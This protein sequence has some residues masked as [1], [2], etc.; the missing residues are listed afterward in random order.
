MRIKLQTTLKTTTITNEITRNVVM[1]LKNTVNGSD[2][3]M[4]SAT[5]WVS[6]G[7]DVLK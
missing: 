2:V 6:N 4:S 7:P 3:I 1:L 5:G